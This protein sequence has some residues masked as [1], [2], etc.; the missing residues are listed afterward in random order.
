MATD[1]LDQP[2]PV[3]AGEELAGDRLADYLAA[4]LPDL[5]GPLTVTQFPAGYS[6]LTYLLQM[7]GRDLV[8]RRPPFGVGK[9]SA[10]DMGRE[11]RVL[12]AL[13]PLYPRVPQPLL[14]C[15]DEAVLGVPF[16][17]MERVPGV[18]LRAR[19]PAGLVLDALVL[20]GLS[21][22]TIDNLAAI[23]ALPLTAP[24]LTAGSH[25]EGYVGRQIAGWARRYGAAKTDEIPEIEGV[26]AWLTDHLP[27]ESGATL[28]HNDY[29]YD[30]LVLNPADL[31]QIRA[32]LDWE[33]ATIG[34]P[35]LDLGTTLGYWV[36]A[37]DPPELQAQSFGITARPGN[38]T[39]PELVARYAAQSG[40]DVSNVVYYYV[41]GLF[42]IAVIVQ[43]IYA[44]YRQGYT[45]DPRFAGLLAVIRTLGQT[46][47]QASA[48]NRLDH[49]L[50]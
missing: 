40:H 34:D 8:L 42:K 30:N 13:A 32:V 38:L 31:T 7:G 44:R 36:E 12:A 15:T 47:A 5:S 17:V 37:D 22:A 46:A 27:P 45:Q 14:Y 18:I 50:D 26:I 35:L 43:Q 19:P 23:H 10:H 20:R 4:H 33:M 41:Y 9:G 21:T 29:K 49:L 6:N 25:P 1:F 28:I 39:R 24:G 16:Y 3:R 11:Y 48:R 2:K